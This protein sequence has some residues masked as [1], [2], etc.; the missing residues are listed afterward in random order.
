LNTPSILKFFRTPIHDARRLIL[1]GTGQPQ[2]L[3]GLKSLFPSIEYDD[4]EFSDLHKIIVSI[5]PLDLKAQ[6][7]KPLLRAQINHSDYRGQ[8][9]LYWASMKGDANAVEN[10][11]LAGADANCQAYGKDTPLHVAAFSQNPRVY[12]LLVMAGADVLFVNSWGDTPLNCACNHRDIVACIKPLIRRGA[13]VNHRNKVGHTPLA[14]AAK[15]NNIS[16]GSF[17][18][19]L[20]AD[21]NISDNGGETPLFRAIFYG[22]HDFIE[23]L[24]QKGG[25]C[26]NI[27][28]KGAT[29]LHYTAQYGDIK[30]ASILESA[31][32]S[33]INPDA[34]DFKGRTAMQVLDQR[35]VIDEGF[36]V[37]FE[38]LLESVR[39]E[40]STNS[41]DSEDSEAYFDTL[42]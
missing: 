3:S 27:T 30:M 31:Q 14:H 18:L 23:L 25:N 10:L 39:G 15:R 26:T 40:F 9:P 1:T 17:L 36:I 12:E 32:L 22:S 35:L 2:H 33:G 29:V 41:E 34:M 38:R 28:V 37:A 6:L 21:M 7:E 4:W 13:N 5:L 24:L 16:I 20:N 8:T 19:D 42:G 11:L